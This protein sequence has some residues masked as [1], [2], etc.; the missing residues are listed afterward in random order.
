MDH[1]RNENVDEAQGFLLSKPLE[2][3]ALE[4]Q[5]LAPSRVTNG[6]AKT[7]THVVG[8]TDTRRCTGRSGRITGPETAD[9]QHL[10]DAVAHGAARPVG[11]R[12][13]RR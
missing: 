2:P 9:T 11:R 5:I 10:G 8:G 4:A 12:A 3:D 7:V 1:L 6:A 13:V